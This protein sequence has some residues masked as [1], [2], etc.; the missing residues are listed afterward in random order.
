MTA[1]LFDD[2]PPVPMARP[3]VVTVAAGVF[4]LRGFARDLDVALLQAV[5]EVTAISPLRHSLTPGGQAM[6]LAMSNCGPLGWVSSRSGYRYEARDPMTGQPW[7]A[8][9]ASLS[10]LALRAAAQ[11]GFAHFRP[12]ACLINQYAPGS[13]LSL[14]QDKDEA[15]FSQPIVSVS[16]G[17]PAVFLLGTTQRRDL[18]QRLRLIHGDV[19]V[20]GGPARL[21]FHGVMTL[22]DG[23]H[24]L[25]GRR[26][27]NLTF[28]KAA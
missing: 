27:V 2:L 12:D 23:A 16:L 1:D 7:P 21:A 14:H 13:K 17:L 11:A 9:P 8:M 22:S 6:S 24:A 5:E 15:D 3:D 18:P 4:L 19:L 26:R 28:R 10:D 25:L 20:W